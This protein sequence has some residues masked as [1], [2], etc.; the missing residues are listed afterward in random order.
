MGRRSRKRGYSGSAG[1]SR[2]VTTTRAQRDAA[3]ERRAARAASGEKPARRRPGRPSIEERPPAPW[4]SFPLVELIVLAA[5]GLFVAGLIIRGVQGGV[6]VIS[7]L[8]LGSLAGLELSIREHLA[9]YRSHSTL[10]AGAAGVAAGMA[11]FFAAGHDAGRVAFLPV[12]LGVFLT[13]FW[14]LRQTF[15]RRSG[16][17]GFRA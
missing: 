4:G 17:L 1:E 11:T 3:R 2:S 6:M 14:F 13:A 8:V 7:A 5:I 10:L 16:G 12:G 9:G 15:K